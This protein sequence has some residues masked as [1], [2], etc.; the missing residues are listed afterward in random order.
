[1]FQQIFLDMDGVIADF[2]AGVRKRYNDF[3]WHPTEWAIPYADMGT[4][5]KDF[6]RDL[7]HPGFWRELPWT[8]DGK[9][10]QALV[11]PMRPI[12]LTAAVMPYAGTGKIQW[13]KR[14]YPDVVKDKRFL[15][16]GGHSGKAAVAGPGK[17]LIDD[18]DENIDEW[19][20]AGGIG[21]LY[22]RPWNRFSHSK[23]PLEYLCSSLMTALDTR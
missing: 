10:I 13:L 19:E 12:I 20:A 22:P 2:D 16:A 21:I 9:R 6:W 14:E 4:N 1:M 3:D 11:E 18:K 7:D 23:N 15:I 17:I 8:H 5:F